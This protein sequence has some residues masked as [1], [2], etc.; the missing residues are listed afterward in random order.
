MRTIL[1]DS[2]LQSE[3]ILKGYTK[4]PLLSEAE[5]NYILRALQALRPH[6]NFAPDG[7][8][9]TTSTYHCSFLDTNVD[10]KRKASQLIRE[11]FSPHI[12]RLLV[13]YEILNCNFYVKPPGTGVF[14]I[15][16]NWPAIEINDT[17]ITVWCP[18]LD[19]DEL[20]GTLQVVEASHKIVPEISGPTGNPFFRNFE[21]ELIEKYLKPL[22]C[23]AGEAVV[24]DDSLIHWSDRNRS[25][26]PRVAIQIL[27][28][29]ADK[30]PV[31]FYLDPEAPEKGFEM[32]EIDGDYF[33]EHTI[34]DLQVRPTGLKSLGFVENRNVA[35]TVEEFAEKLKHGDEIRQ[36]IY[37]S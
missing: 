9:T 20:N 22:P 4:I 13:G 8:G 28:V 24:F 37:A 29:P 27:C 19:T 31:F 35:L 36:K 3:L 6:D 17:S 34:T 15:H 11:V 30:T 25:A 26:S 10:Y 33:V 7:Q 2:T 5:V 12:R 21:A 32:F 18:L 16:Q 23:H 1:S 14:Q